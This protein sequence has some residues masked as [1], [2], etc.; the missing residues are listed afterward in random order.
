MPRGL[1]LG[2]FMRKFGGLKTS[3]LRRASNILGLTLIGLLTSGCWGP[4]TVRGP[5]RLFAPTAETGAMQGLFSDT[6]QAW[7]SYLRVE[8]SKRK[9]YR[10]EIMAARMYAVDVNYTEYEHALNVEG[11][12]V[13]FWAKLGSGTLSTIAT[14][15]PVAQTIRGLN[16]VAQGVTLGESAYTDTF[17]R[18]F[19]TQNLIASMRAARSER[20]AV[21]R[22][23]MTCGAEIY[24][25][26]LAL[27]DIESYYRAGSIET[28]MLRL[29]RTST[30]DE[31]KAKSNDDVAGATAPPVA[32]EIQARTNA[33][34][35]VAD[36]NKGTDNACGS[37]NIS[38]LLLDD[39]GSEM[40]VLSNPSRLAVRKPKATPKQPP[41]DGTAV[42]RDHA[43]AVDKKS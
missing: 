1:N 33:M 35:A 4:P 17:F 9:G 10:N 43:P 40:S 15:V 41:R 24:P 3:A 21:I 36:A 32:K 13:E 42:T 39:S 38:S 26:G 16:A 6:G 14:A 31:H 22:S 5:D 29:S 2:G 20:R 23:R 37:N 25:L 34:T 28:G 11:Q 8:D 30:S 18:K 19:M 7:K 27:S 12:T